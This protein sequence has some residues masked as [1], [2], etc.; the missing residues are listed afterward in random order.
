MEKFDMEVV[1]KYEDLNEQFNI[2]ENYLLTLNDDV[3]KV[4]Y[5]FFV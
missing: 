1:N 5:N 4:K 3:L 2:A